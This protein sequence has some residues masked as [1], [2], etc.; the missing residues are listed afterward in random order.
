MAELFFTGTTRAGRELRLWYEHTKY[1]TYQTDDG[2]YDDP[3]ETRITG[4][5][6]GEPVEILDFSWRAGDDGSAVVE[7][8]EHGTF[9]A[10]PD[11]S[12]DTHRD[13]LRRYLHKRPLPRDD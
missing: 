4:T 7:T 10:L 13:A 8:A 3:A 5:L 1:V 2:P 6:D 12:D 9:S 11:E